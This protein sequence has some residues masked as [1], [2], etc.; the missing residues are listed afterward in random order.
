[1]FLTEEQYKS[2]HKQNRERAQLVKEMIKTKHAED[3]GI[4]IKTYGEPML[5]ETERELQDWLM[6]KRIQ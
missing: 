6:H 1:M 3:D 5:F 2:M 4:E